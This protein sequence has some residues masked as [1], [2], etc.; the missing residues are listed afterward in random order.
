MT[1]DTE[2]PELQLLRRCFEG[3]GNG[4]YTCIEQALAKDARWI[5]AI[6]DAPGCAGR[7]TIVEV[8]SRN[9]ARGPHGT[10]EDMTQY[11]SRVLVAFRPDTPADMQD[12]PLDHGL[13]YMVVT[14][15]GGEITELRGCADSAA[16]LEFAQAA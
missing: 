8:M 5:A 13:A 4:D 1:L 12:R 3:W 9:T 15:S 6:E 14:V 10:I 2:S 11:G 7:E 16:A